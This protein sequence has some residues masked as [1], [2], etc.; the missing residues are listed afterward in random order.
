MVFGWWIDG[1]GTDKNSFT[2]MFGTLGVLEARGL[3]H[4]E[5][6]SEC[7]HMA[8]LGSRPSYLAA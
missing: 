4:L 6:P 3:A 7:P 8:V 5:V 1:S 2:H